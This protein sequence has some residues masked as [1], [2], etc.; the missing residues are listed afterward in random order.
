VAGFI[1]SPTMNSIAGT[2]AGG[3]EA[4]VFKSAD[5]SFRL[6]GGARVSGPVILGIRPEGICVNKADG[7]SLC[8][9]VQAAIEVVELLGYKR[10]LYLKVGEKLLLATV[11]ASFD[12]KPGDAVSVRFQLAGIHI[13]DKETKS[14]IG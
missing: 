10:N 11:D 13:F 4:P 3:P 2:V 1:G 7:C 14:R 5:M 6:A 12:G 9:P 8:E